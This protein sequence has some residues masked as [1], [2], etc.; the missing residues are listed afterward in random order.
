MRMLLF[1]L[2]TVLALTV[3]D[4]TAYEFSEHF[5]PWQSPCVTCHEIAYAEG[6]PLLSETGRPLKFATRAD[7]N[8]YAREYIDP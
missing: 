3:D 2:P 7:A 8:T 4:K 1:I 6:V 5:R